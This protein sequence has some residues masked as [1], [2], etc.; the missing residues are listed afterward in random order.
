MGRGTS[1][2]AKPSFTLF[3]TLVSRAN[4][5]IAIPRERTLGETRVALTPTLVASLRRDQ[6]E[7]CVESGAGLAAGFTDTA[8]AEAG[9]TIVTD[10]AALLGSAQAVFKVQPP[11]DAEAKLLPAGCELICHLA[12]FAHGPLIR[13][14][15]TQGVTAYAMEFIPRIPRAHRTGAL[16][17][18]ATVAGYKAVLVGAAAMP[19]MFPLL[20]TAAGTVSPAHVLILGAGVAGLQA[21]ATAR[22]LGARVEAFDPRPAVR[23]Q[24]KS[25]GAAF[26]EMELPKDVETSGGYAKELSPEFI[27]KEMEA[28]GGRL[29]KMDLVVTTAQIFGKKA[30]LL[31]SAD[32]VRLMK[33]GSVIVDLAA[34]QGGNCELT[35]A[36]ETIDAWGVTIIGTRN[37]PATVAFDASGLYAKNVFNLFKLLHPKADA[38][39]DWED[40]VVKGACLTRGGSIVH[41]SVRAAL[42]TERPA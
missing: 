20:M 13:R 33:P 5:K 42:E 24:V 10:L 8:Y 14:L 32:M 2:F 1:D 28:I 40:E 30:P 36:G 19:K 26:V 25:L 31:I 27:Q 38:A 3:L 12:P 29:P 6:H 41:A 17:S 15:A 21:S 18:Q 4:V 7:L 34:E 22:R 11:D 35:R 23:E 9:A 37:L 39:P 16:S